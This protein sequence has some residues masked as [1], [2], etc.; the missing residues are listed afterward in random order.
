MDLGYFTSE[1]SPEA[2]F[3]DTGAV[4]Q[5]DKKMV[6]IINSNS[7]QIIED[8][9]K[10]DKIKLSSANLGFKHFDDIDEMRDYVTSSLNDDKS[11]QPAP[12][13]LCMAL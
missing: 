11:D 5:C 2:D 4:L 1:T 12:T 7:Q 8:A 9:F 3:W 13:E 10:E 6:G